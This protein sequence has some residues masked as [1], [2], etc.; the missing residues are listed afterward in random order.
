MNISDKLKTILK[1]LYTELLNHASK[2]DCTFC[3]QWGKKFP[4][5]NNEGILFVGRAT[6]GWASEFDVDKMFDDD[7]PDRIFN[8]PEQM[9]WMEQNRFAPQGEYNNNRSAFLRV[10]RKTACHFFSSD[11]WYEY[12]AWSNLCK[13]APDV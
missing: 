12:V 8:H 4:V 3:V 6:N 2:Q 1:P 9:V 5:E 10:I 7:N 13:L 11:E